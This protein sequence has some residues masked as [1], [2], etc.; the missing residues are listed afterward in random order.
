MIG[1]VKSLSLWVLKSAVQTRNGEAL[2][3][4]DAIRRRPGNQEH[5]RHQ[6]AHSPMPLDLA[7]PFGCVAAGILDS[8]YLFQLAEIPLRRV[9]DKKVMSHAA[10]GSDLRSQKS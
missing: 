5:P 6:A 8:R 3:S 1:F 4:F 7:P 9:H 10:L 2:R